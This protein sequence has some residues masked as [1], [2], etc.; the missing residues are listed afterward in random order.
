MTLDEMEARLE[1]EVLKLDELERIETEL[2]AEI[3]RLRAAGTKAGI[4]SGDGSKLGA[5]A[6]RGGSRSKARIRA[7]AIG[8]ARGRGGRQR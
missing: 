8:R 6:K 1:S 4:V 3:A 5:P 7:R 2:Q